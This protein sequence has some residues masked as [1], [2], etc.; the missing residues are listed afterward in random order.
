[1]GC[2]SLSTREGRA[3]WKVL[4]LQREGPLSPIWT[5]RAGVGVLQKPPNGAPHDNV[6]QG[7]KPTQTNTRELSGRQLPRTVHGEPLSSLEAVGQ[8]PLSSSQDRRLA[9]KE[10]LHSLKEGGALVTTC[11]DA[12]EQHVQD[13]TSAGTSPSFTTSCRTFLPKKTSAE[14][15][16][17]VL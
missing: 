10:R 14:A 8:V 9:G 11:R 17:S 4:L 12:A 7:E 3:C 1:M 13:G 6:E 16:S 5:C 2:P 15:A